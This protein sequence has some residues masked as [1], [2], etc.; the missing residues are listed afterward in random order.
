MKRG[1]IHDQ[2]ARTAVNRSELKDLDEV[3][4]AHLLR[5]A[6]LLGKSA[7]QNQCRPLRWPKKLI[8][9]EIEL[10]LRIFINMQNITK[11]YKVPVDPIGTKHD[12][13]R[14]TNGHARKLE[15]EDRME[16]YTE[17]PCY[18]T[19]KDHKGNFSNNPKCRLINPAKSNLGRV[20][21]KILET[22]TS[23]IKMNTGANLWKSTT[24]VL[25]WFKNLDDLLGHRGF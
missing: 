14:R 7:C 17:T 6:G 13:N 1:D 12:I 16:C 10:L 5:H 15:I 22:L 9:M 25:T 24:D 19:L 23:A 21:K 8:Q 18:I 4:S 20:S 3:S 11:D 2:F